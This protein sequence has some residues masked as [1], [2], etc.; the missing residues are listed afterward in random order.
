VIQSDISRTE[1]AALLS[2]E[3][4]MVNAIV[5]IHPGAGGVEAQDWAR[6]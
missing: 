2:E 4:D 5:S 3:L 1:I 6:C